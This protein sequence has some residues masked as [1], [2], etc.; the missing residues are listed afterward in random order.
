MN[1]LTTLNPYG[2][3]SA[4][5]TLTIQRLLP[6]PADLVWA[7]LTETDLRRQWLAAGE[8]EMTPGSAFELVWR[9]DDLSD[10]PAE[11]PEGFKEE[12]RMRGRIT[13]LDRPRKLSMTWD[14]SG[15]VTFELEPQ[16]RKVL[17]TVI[18]RGLTDRA[19]LL[20]IAAGWHMHL[21][22]LVARSRGQELGSF[23]AGWS[24][25]RQ[26]YDRRFAA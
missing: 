9:N 7:A 21:D 26:D 2:V 11:R 20:A 13:K 25:L 1:D 8:M 6:G 12:Y 14:G 22:I 15:E 5:A 3:L 24:R 16:G 10:P 17:L 19:T 23:W 18:H 4:P